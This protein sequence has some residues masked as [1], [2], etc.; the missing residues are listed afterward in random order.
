MALD[1]QPLAHASGGA[2]I[3]LLLLA[4]ALTPSLDVST[5]PYRQA[6]T[7]GALGVVSGQAIADSLRPGGSPQPVTEVAVT[8]VPRS[9]VLL[10]EL[11]RI[12]GRSRSEMSAY[13]TSARAVTDARR[14]Y[15]RALWDSGAVE[16]IRATTTD[17]EGRFSV[18]GLPAGAW[19]L[20]AQRAVFVPKGSGP[21]SKRDRELF[22]RRPQLTGYYAVTFWLREITIKAGQATDVELTDRNAWMTGIAEE[23]LDVG[24]QGRPPARPARPY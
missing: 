23:R 22:D 14:G 15:E 17:P 9:E 10:A 11:E 16:L 4:V 2:M 5:E 24:P 1:A 8:L 18:E 20:L 19:L 21:M 6:A 12:R 7:T 3:P 13:R